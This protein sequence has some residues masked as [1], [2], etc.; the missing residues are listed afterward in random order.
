M[1]SSSAT[2][3][4]SYSGATGEIV[5]AGIRWGYSS[6]TMNRNA[7]VDN[8]TTPFSVTIS[9]LDP[10]TL[11]YYR[12]YVVEY[13]N[14]NEVDRQGEVRT[15]TTKKVATATVTTGSATATSAGATLQGSWSGATGTVTD[16]GFYWGT[17]QSSIQNP[18]T[19]T[20]SVSLGSAS[21]TSGSLTGELSSLESS[22]TYYYRAY[23]VEFDEAQNKYVDRLGEIKSFTTT[24]PGASVNRGYLDCYEMPAISG[25]TYGEKGTESQVGPWWNYTTSNSKQK[26]V[27]HAFTYGG[28]QLRNYTALIDADKKAPLWSAF[29]MHSGAYPDNN[30]GRND[31]W[32]DDPAIPSSWQQG[33][34][35]NYSRGHLVASNYRQVSVA[36]NKQTFYHT[37]QAPQYQNGFNDG[38][39]NSMEQAIKANAPSSASD[40]LYV[41]VGVLYENNN[42]S[43]GVPVP[44][45]FYTCLMKCHFSGGA[46]TSANGCAY[47]FTNEAHNGEKYGDAITTIDAIES[48]AGFDFF[49]NVPTSL[50]NT[51]E[52]QS[53]SLW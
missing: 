25:A 38:V 1:T 51:A 9:G 37:N 26:V 45:H 4:G 16:R 10:G 31:S 22:K 36:A 34:V 11:I 32:R 42:T 18:T 24:A 35:S 49:A 40:T 17:T 44:S 5:H 23:V 14:G 52:G 39:W 7:Y 50:Q 30:A 15:F 28:K 20:P 46:M 8:I 6:G 53:A 12:A 48:R 27:S 33:G 19:T 41:V 21:G 43:N 47:I 29:V 13:V 3:S 2:L